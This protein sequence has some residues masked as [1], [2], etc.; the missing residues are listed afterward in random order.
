MRAIAAHD[1]G[2]PARVRALIAIAAASLLLAAPASAA[3]GIHPLAPKGAVERG[4]APTF[5]MK[6]N[7]RGAVFVH[8]CRSAKRTHG[9][10]CDRET[11]GQAKRGKGGIYTFKPRVFKFPGYFLNR[12]GTYYWQAVRIACSGG[13]C[14]QEGPVTRFAVR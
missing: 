7:G 13:D 11:T 14:R 9:A 8:V 6:V 10:I 4:A 12:P 1:G 2:Y 3:S 5:R